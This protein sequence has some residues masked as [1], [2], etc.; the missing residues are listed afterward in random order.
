MLCTNIA[1]LPPNSKE[2]VVSQGP[3]TWLYFLWDWAVEKDRAVTGLAPHCSEIEHTGE[4][5]NN[6]GEWCVRKPVLSFSR[7]VLRVKNRKENILQD[8][9]L[10]SSSFV[11]N[12]LPC[13]YLENCILDIYTKSAVN[14]CLW[15]RTQ[16]KKN[17]M[18]LWSLL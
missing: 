15:R 18:Q 8:L 9:C 16:T 17:C 10:Q 3:V 13:I 14:Y 2:D 5:E 6:T 7:N 11:S 4:K 12:N 1:P